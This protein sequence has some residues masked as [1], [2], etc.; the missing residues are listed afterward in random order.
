MG[1]GDGVS[2]MA[3]LVA[4]GMGTTKPEAA[5]AFAKAAAVLSPEELSRV[6]AKGEAAPLQWKHNL[7]LGA[8][9][10]IDVPPDMKRNLSDI[11]ITASRAIGIRFCS[12]DVADVKGEGLMIVEV[13]GGVMM[14]SLIGLMGAAGQE[15]SMRVYENAVLAALGLQAAESGAPALKRAR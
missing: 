3:A 6:P 2:S 14:D 9:V 7:G 10:D 12:V 13:N 8:G 1:V 11:A 5:A 4:Q 15:L